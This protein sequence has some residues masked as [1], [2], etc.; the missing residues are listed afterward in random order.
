MRQ[1]QV[2]EYMNE[3]KLELG[4]FNKMNEIIQK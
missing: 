3:L 1:F 2:E 4:H